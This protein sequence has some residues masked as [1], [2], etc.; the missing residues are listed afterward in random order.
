MKNYV[1][2]KRLADH[3]RGLAKKRKGPRYVF[4]CVH[5]RRHKGLRHE[6]LLHPDDLHAAVLHCYALNLA[7]GHPPSPPQRRPRQEG[8]RS[9]AV[10]LGDPS[11]LEL[12]KAFCRALIKARIG[13]AK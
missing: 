3:N 12:A 13:G 10:A 11:D 8:V 4:C 9:V 7:S 1:I 6:F 2:S 5:V